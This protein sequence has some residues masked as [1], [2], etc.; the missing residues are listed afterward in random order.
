MRVDYSFLCD[1]A[2]GVA[3]KLAAIG[4]GVDAI[5]SRSFPVTHLMLHYVVRVLG[6]A[7]EAGEHPA[8]IT[9]DGPDGPVREPVALEL[10]L[11][12]PHGP[13]EYGAAQLNLKLVG[14]RFPTPGMYSIVLTLDDQV[15]D[16]RPLML[17]LGNEG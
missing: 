17:A 4:I 8:T 15:I 6:S 14:L 16:R 2:D 12:A 1:Y 10:V 13:F 7:D 11:P 9:V 3:G 5:T